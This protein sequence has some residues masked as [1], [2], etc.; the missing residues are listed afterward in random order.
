[1][2][3]APAA[4]ASATCSPSR[5]KSAARIEGAILIE[6]LAMLIPFQPAVAGDQ[7]VSRAVVGKLRI[8]RGFQFGHDAVGKDLAELDT[9]LVK[10]VDVPDRPLNENAVLVQGDQL[11]E[12][13]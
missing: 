6:P 1:M 5:A 3:S 13:G 9:P 10:R 7:R 2:R 4:S 12:G 11:A 8:G